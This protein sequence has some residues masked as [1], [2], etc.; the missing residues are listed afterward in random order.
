[1]NNK[2]ITIGIV[3]GEMS[4]DILGS[5]LIKAIK[6]QYPNAIFE[7]IGGPG[8][9]AQ[10]CKSRFAMEELSVMGL[11]EVLGRLR[12]LLDVRKQLVN[13]F[14]QNPPDVFIGIDAPD[15]NLGLET[16]L[17]AAGIKTVHY[18]SPSV[19]AWRKKRIFKIKKAVNL[20]LCLLPFE[21][22]IYQEHNIPSEFVG[23]TLADEIPLEVDQ[24]AAR[25][26]LNVAYDKKVLAILPGSRGTELSMLA[27]P[28]LQTAIKLQQKYDDLVVVVPVVNDKRKEQLLAIKA[29]IAPD[30]EL[31]IV[32]GQSTDVMSACDVVMLA[33]GTATL[34][35]ALLKRPMVV[36]YKFKWLS[37]Q[38]FSRMIKVDHFSLPNLLAG[39]G[40]VPEVLQDQ[41]EPDHLSQL[42]DGYF[43]GDNSQL[44]GEFNSIH[45]TLRLNASEHAAKA[46]L[47]LLQ[48]SEV[49]ESK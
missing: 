26:K 15:F 41:V 9:I 39:K 7:G 6:Q 38:I 18:V 44:I 22:K 4:G 28:F 20:V 17:K 19:W 36:A 23:H 31:V 40:L 42:V 5:G 34:E 49:S 24:K 27:A 12:R 8:M 33:S 47:A 1:M 21:R 45:Q 48:S 32:D 3:A 29:Q 2:V 14:I 16:K 10:G 30:L 37:Y 25:D 46:V 13:Y 35:A 11:V 43:S